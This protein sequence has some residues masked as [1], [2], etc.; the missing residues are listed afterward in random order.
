MTH[1]KGRTGFLSFDALVVLV[2]QLMIS[3]L[4]EEIAWRAF[5][6]KQ[7]SKMIP[8]IPSLIISSALF[9]LCHFTPASVAVVVYD[10]IFI[11]INA[12][13]YGLIFRRTDN[14]CVS[15][16]AHFLANMLGVVMIMAM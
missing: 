16:I 15:A 3:A 7:T 8:F 5:F 13:I 10:L 6:Q 12:V 9:S 4:G 14:A 1:L 11:F 2:V